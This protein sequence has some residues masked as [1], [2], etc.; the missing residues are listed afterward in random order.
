MYVLSQ[1]FNQLKDNLKKINPKDGDDDFIYA[2]FVPP[3]FPSSF[4]LL[5]FNIITL[6]IIIPEH[7]RCFPTT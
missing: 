5:N 4:A 3:I 7:F 1:F 6:P 2:D